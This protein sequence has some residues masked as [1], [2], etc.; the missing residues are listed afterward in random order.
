MFT[1]KAI[2]NFLLLMCNNLL[3]N[4]NR[5]CSENFTTINCATVAK[6]VL[7][8]MTIKY[9]FNYLINKVLFTD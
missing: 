1:Y 7:D 4:F 9:Y 2:L 8:R 6:I 3:E 5:V